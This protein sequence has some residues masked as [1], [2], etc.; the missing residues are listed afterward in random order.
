MAREELQSIRLE[1]KSRQKAFMLY[2]ML[3]GMFISLLVSCNLIFLKFVDWKPFGWFDGYISVGVFPYP[4][5]FLVTDL[6]SEIYGRKRADDIVKVGL[7]ASILVMCV[8]MV[9]DLIPAWSNSPI[10]DQTFSSVFGLAAA[11][12]TG[13]M[14][15]YLLAQFIDIRIYHFWKKKT[16][17]KHL[18]LRNNFSTFTSQIVDTLIVL[19]ILC[20]LG[21]LDWSLFPLLLISGITFKM[22]VAALDTPLLYL[23]V[24][25]IR[26]RFNLKRNQEIALD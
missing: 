18:W 1:G 12:V 9:A 26:K 11:G 6:I 8:T 10:D 20:S 19:T 5:T 13:S 14:I 23:F 3:G 24:F 4:I 7:V 17:G 21:A 2:L 22:M 16:Q 25:L 15:A